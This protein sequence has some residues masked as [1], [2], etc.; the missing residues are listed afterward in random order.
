MYV[1]RVFIIDDFTNMMPKHLQY[2]RK[3]IA[4]KCSE[5]F[6]ETAENNKNYKTFYDQVIF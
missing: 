2:H 5:L 6:A 3:N 4:K 1:R